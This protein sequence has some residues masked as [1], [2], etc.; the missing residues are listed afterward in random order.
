MFS[1]LSESY[2][3][4]QHLKTRK[5]YVIGVVVIKQVKTLVFFFLLVSMVFVFSGCGGSIGD[6]QVSV[7][8]SRA[9]EQG[10]DTWL[11]YAASWGVSK[12][13]D[14]CDSKV[15][16]PVD[17]IKGTENCKDAF[18]AGTAA[19]NYATNNEGSDSKVGYDSE[20]GEPSTSCMGFEYMKEKGGKCSSTKLRR[21]KGICIVSACYA[22]SGPCQYEPDSNSGLSFISECNDPAD[23]AKGGLCKTLDDMGEDYCVMN[24]LQWMSDGDDSTTDYCCGD[25]PGEDNDYGFV[26]Y[27]QELDGPN[28]E[29]STSLFS[30]NY[31][32]GQCYTLNRDLITNHITSME[33]DIESTTMTEC[34]PDEHFNYGDDP[35]GCS[36]DNP[37]KAWTDYCVTG[38]SSTYPGYYTTVETYQPSDISADL[39]TFNPTCSGSQG[40][41]LCTY[42]KGGITL[43]QVVDGASECLDG[44]LEL[45]YKD[46]GV[47]RARPIG[48]T[49]GTVY[50]NVSN[51]PAVCYNGEPYPN[52]DLSYDACKNLITLLH[53]EDTFG[54]Q[55][56]VSIPS[57][58]GEGFCCG[59]DLGDLGLSV[60]DEAGVMHV[61]TVSEDGKYAWKNSR[62]HKGQ[63]FDVYNKAEFWDLG[64]D[65][66]KSRD[67]GV[68]EHFLVGIGD[69]FVVA[70]DE[71]SSSLGSGDTINRIPGGDYQGKAD[72]RGFYCMVNATPSWDNSYNA[73][74]GAPKGTLMMASCGGD[75]SLDSDI[76]LDL[77]RGEYALS[78]GK[79]ATHF[80]TGAGYFKS[81]LDNFDTDTYYIAE[82]DLSAEDVV[83]DEF[84]GDEFYA[85]L[86]RFWRTG[87]AT[88][89]DD[90]V[91]SNPMDYEFYHDTATM[92]TLGPD[93]VMPR[94]CWNGR[95]VG[96][97]ATIATVIEDS[98]TL[99]G[100]NLLRFNVGEYFFKGNT[101][102]FLNWLISFPE[103]TAGQILGNPMTGNYVVG[104][105]L[106][107]YDVNVGVD[108]YPEV[109]FETKYPVHLVKDI[110]YV[111]IVKAFHDNGVLA[112]VFP[113]ID[114]TFS[115]PATYT[116]PLHDTPLLL[117]EELGLSE[118]VLIGS[119]HLT[120]TPTTTGSYDVTFKV[121]NPDDDSDVQFSVLELRPRPAILNDQGYLYAC[122][123]KNGVDRFT[124]LKVTNK[125]AITDSILI[126]DEYT[127]D[128]C[129]VE[130]GAAQ[131]GSV[132]TPEGT[133]L[134][135]EDEDA[136]RAIPEDTWTSE[137]TRRS[138]VS[139]SPNILEDSSFDHGNGILS[140]DTGCTFISENPEDP[141][142]AST[143]GDLNERMN[144][145]DDVGVRSYLKCSLSGRRVPIK[146][147][148][149]SAL[150]A[151][152]GYIFSAWVKGSGTIDI[153][154]GVEGT[155][156]V[157]EQIIGNKVLL[158]YSVERGPVAIPST[159]QRIEVH[160]EAVNGVVTLLFDGTF[161][162]DGVQLEEAHF[163]QEERGKYFTTVVR[164]GCCPANACWDGSKCTYLD[165]KSTNYLNL[166]DE[167]LANPQFVTNDDEKGYIC[168]GGGS[169]TFREKKYRWVDN[170]FEDAGKI[171][172]YVNHVAP[173][174]FGFCEPSSC[175]VGRDKADVDSDSVAII[176]NRS[177]CVPGSDNDGTPEQENVFFGRVCEAGEWTTNTEHLAS[178]L[179][180]IGE[181]RQPY[182]LYCG[183]HEDVLNYANYDFDITDEDT[184]LT[185]VL[186][187]TLVD[188]VSV[189]VPTVDK[190][191]VLKFGSDM[192][193]ILIGLPLND[194]LTDVPDVLQYFGRNLRVTGTCDNFENRQSDAFIACMNGNR[195]LYNDLYN[196][197]LYT[198]EPRLFGDLQNQKIAD[199]VEQSNWINTLKNHFLE[200]PFVENGE[201]YE[202]AL[203]RHDNYDELFMFKNEDD[204]QE[205]LVTRQ[206]L[207]N[208]EGID[209]NFYYLYGVRM[210]GFEPDAEFVEAQHINSPVFPEQNP[211]LVD[212]F[213]TTNTADVVIE[214][215]DEYVYGL[216]VST[217]K[218][219]FNDWYM[220]TGRLRGDVALP[221]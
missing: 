94:A 44:A 180:S 107:F 127:I 188:D 23:A 186:D 215:G 189:K 213:N 100:F 161:E 84:Y 6:C 21:N 187:E 116:E 209:N 41:K 174:Q 121:P 3:N 135:A 204:N 8:K 183:D 34:C 156:E 52:A 195:M 176:M 89:G 144:S 98:T 59:D 65:V 118:D 208:Y 90:L 22:V 54:D 72:G 130:K 39:M 67:V 175:F 50:T 158:P 27:L 95:V 191:C 86:D 82:E 30:F 110:E 179:S 171:D 78:F 112:N 58:T 9:V 105:K 115:G 85:P 111:L 103:R 75:G 76:Q 35:A 88:C 62:D 168:V 93:N 137:N 145:E 206:K 120:F 1:D 29:A 119:R 113:D 66:M 164:R 133:W 201:M 96:N 102:G 91:Q 48:Q 56:W 139:T 178:F 2:L 20:N 14:N 101:N 181:E 202:E 151:E 69:S 81:E 210:Q 32:Y 60:E 134:P 80:C 4:R 79:T 46:D 43:Y 71:T 83:L 108:P 194:D 193:N 92:T 97:G 200:Y 165:G 147:P 173:T 45:N 33:R 162:I 136:K 132:C 24:G 18:F 219:A 124:T 140:G 51:V 16:E 37:T 205:I 87:S 212:V 38:E 64:I 129:A 31:N 26:T 63:V 157:P 57:P 217:D 40:S 196:V 154:D 104:D 106:R 36:G 172:E 68:A 152:Y 123:P 122:A 170:E 197:L 138:H 177:S 141:I 192:K 216:Y 73:I 169:Y 11:E 125:N 214:N 184:S 70:C 160:G 185:N 117:G 190:A 126:S 143:Q 198:R 146:D 211:T 153:L 166:G 42:T 77:V 131:G 203:L 199:G 150:N 17:N 148:D 28:N 53:S 114:V 12:T 167:L 10:H 5:V 55:H 163:R 159:W 155:Q 221:Q 128:F 220:F 25:Q 15:T 99:I 74:G 182:S 19:S 61:C 207:I 218:S 7:I 49:S 109:I 142:V 47:Y 149:S 13:K